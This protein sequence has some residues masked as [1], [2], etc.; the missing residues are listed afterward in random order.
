M[1]EMKTQRKST[2]KSIPPEPSLLLSV[3]RSIGTTLGTIA[4]KAGSVP[5]VQKP[6]PRPSRARKTRAK[7]AKSTR[8]RRRA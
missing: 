7:S 4:A 8:T 5:S 6:A 1:S 3:A 2:R